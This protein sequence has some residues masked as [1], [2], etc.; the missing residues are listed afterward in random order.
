VNSKFIAILILVSFLSI[1]RGISDDNIH[2]SSR[3][4]SP[5]AVGDKLPELVLT[6]TD[7]H[8]V[9]VHDYLKEQPLIL[10]YY[11]GGW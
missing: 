4:I 11:R 2:S 7:F 5:I 9:K 3:R 10:I 8:D 1:T 6:D